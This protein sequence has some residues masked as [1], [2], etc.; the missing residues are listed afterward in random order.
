MR[1]KQDYYFTSNKTVYWP[2]EYSN[3]VNLL[4]GQSV[5]GEE[6]NPG[7]YAHNTYPVVLAAIIGLVHN[8]TRPVSSPSLQIE[9]ETFTNHEY[10]GV[11]LVG[12]IF[13]IPLIATK[14][15]DL[16][17]PENEDKLIRIFEGYAS[18]GFEYLRGALS[19]S[20]DEDGSIVF[21]NE[22]RNAMRKF[23]QN[24][25]KSNL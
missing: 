3:I 1:N 7:M 25:D 13:L 19:E 6:I 11:R 2:T 22:I 18:G 21:Q 8:R 9:T 24:L 20:T 12:F 14:D 23:N 5:S 17:K 4:K 10:G 15:L 16:L